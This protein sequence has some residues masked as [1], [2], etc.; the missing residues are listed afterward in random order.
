MVLGILTFNYANKLVDIHIDN[1]VLFFNITLQELN[2]MHW[3]NS[4]SVY[5]IVSEHIQL[6]IHLYVALLILLFKQVTPMPLE[7]DTGLQHM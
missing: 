3:I 5:S 4:L 1:S 6:K 7:K 2:Q